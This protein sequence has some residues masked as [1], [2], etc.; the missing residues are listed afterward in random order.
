MEAVQNAAKHS[1]ASLVTVTVSAH[2]KSVRLTVDDDGEGF[3]VSSAEGGTGLTNMRDRIDAAGGSLALTSTP[4]VG[5]RVD[6]HVPLV[7][8]PE[9]RNP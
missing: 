3:D 1:L 6:V 5:T 8:M 9:Q 4:R 2:D 7:Q